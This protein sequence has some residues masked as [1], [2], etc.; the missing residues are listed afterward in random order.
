MNQCKNCK[1]WDEKSFED[2]HPEYNEQDF[3][4]YGWQPKTARY[5]KNPNLDEF[6]N[7]DVGDGKI[8]VMPNFGCVLWEAKTEG[9]EFDFV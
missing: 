7:L 9:G 2:L 5:C 4:T 8:I 6:C 1:W 3:R